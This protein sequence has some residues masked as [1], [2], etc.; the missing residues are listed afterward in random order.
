M[1]L[2][3][4]YI[5]I[6]NIY[7]LSST[8]RSVSFYQNSSVW[9]D[10]LDSWSWD[11]NPV[12]SNANPRFYHSNEETSASKGNLNDYESQLF[13]FTYIRLTATESSIHRIWPEITYNG[14]YA[15]IPNHSKSI[16]SYL[17]RWMF[18]NSKTI[19]VGLIFFFLNW[20]LMKSRLQDIQASSFY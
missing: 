20:H 16:K 13:L 3:I 9:L 8:D 19:K 15:I 14:W 7:I 2:R 11:Q 10:R 12:D 6:F 5:Y 4:I 17:F 18:R 1:C